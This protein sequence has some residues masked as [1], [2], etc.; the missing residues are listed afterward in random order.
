MVYDFFVCLLQSPQDPLAKAMMAVHGMEDEEEPATVQYVIE[1][2]EKDG[3]ED[4]S[5]SEDKQ[6]EEER[7]EEVSQLIDVL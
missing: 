7:S 4:G 6:T 5:N 1:H 2:S 3:E